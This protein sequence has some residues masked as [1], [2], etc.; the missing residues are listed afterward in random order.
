MSSS[1]SNFQ[2]LY[3]QYQ[4]AIRQLQFIEQQEAQVEGIIEEYNSN[5]ATLQGMKSYTDNSE[6]LLPLG[7]MLLLK[8][9]L[10]SIDEILV[11]VGSETIVPTDLETAE[12]MI[13]SRLE[14]MRGALNR[15]LSDKQQL[16]S[17]ATSL[18]TQL[19]QAQQ[20]NT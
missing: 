1:S 10:Q 14:N 11:D 13:K 18:Q 3:N 12:N 7:G 20:A 6:I 17:I 19:N 16:E 2:S 8:A 5:L 9:D 15:L 4:S